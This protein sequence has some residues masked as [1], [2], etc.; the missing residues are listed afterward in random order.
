MR[1][2]MRKK[3]VVLDNIRYICKCRGLKLGEVERKAGVSA[4]YVART[5]KIKSPSFE[6][7]VRFAE[8]LGVP[9]EYLADE[10]LERK[11]K[12]SQLKRIIAEAQEEL[13]KYE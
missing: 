10:D 9:W 2:E 3:D 1:N 11:E 13:K 5:K 7:I 12:V 4:G 6:N 8:V